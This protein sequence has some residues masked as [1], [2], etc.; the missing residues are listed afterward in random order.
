M[1]VVCRP[2]P[3]RSSLS[4][5]HVSSL[6]FI[7]LVWPPL[8]GWDPLSSVQA[9]IYDGRRHANYTACMARQHSENVKEASWSEFWKVFS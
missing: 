2:T 9:W 8:L 3:L 6:L 1:N 5:E 7:S 4:T